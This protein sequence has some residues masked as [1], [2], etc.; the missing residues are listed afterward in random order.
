MSNTGCSV[1]CCNG[2]R[3]ADQ[4]SPNMVSKRIFRQFERKLNTSVSKVFVRSFMVS[5]NS[6]RLLVDIS[7]I[8]CDSLFYIPHSNI[9]YFIKSLGSVTTPLIAAAAA[10]NGLASMVRE[11]GP[12]RPSKFLLVVETAYFPSGI[13]SS[14]IAK[15]A[16]HPG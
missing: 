9:S 16:E 11:P 1:I 14:F 5:L 6:A 13:L 7:V 10:V 8:I 2:S 12:W 15:H 3:T 4:L